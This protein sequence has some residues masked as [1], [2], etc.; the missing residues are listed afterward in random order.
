MN[1]KNFFSFIL[2]PVN[3]KRKIS[4]NLPFRMISN[5]KRSILLAVAITKTGLFFSDNQLIKVAKYSITCT[6]ITFAFRTCL[7]LYRFHQSIRIQGEIVSATLIIWRSLD[8]DSPTIPPNNLP[9]SNFSN[10]NCQSFAIALAVKD[11]PVPCNS[12]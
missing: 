12:D 11:F 8:S 1:F 6:T 7:T 2:V 9:T 5:G 10:G 4:S 3:L